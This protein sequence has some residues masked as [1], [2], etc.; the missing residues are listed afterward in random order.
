M[1]TQSTMHTL[2][3]A[4]PYLHKAIVFDR[5]LCAKQTHQSMSMFHSNYPIK[6]N[7]FTTSRLFQPTRICV[8]IRATRSGLG[9]M[10]CAKFMG[11][12]PGSVFDPVDKQH[13]LPTL[14]QPIH[15]I[16]YIPMLATRGQLRA[17]PVRFSVCYQ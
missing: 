15:K 6:N 7:K 10:F 14:I 4:I 2:P 11:V 16:N 13:S 5:I 8:E 12:I 17:K 9:R 1:F 3:R